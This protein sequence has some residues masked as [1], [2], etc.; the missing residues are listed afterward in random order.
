MRKIGSGIQQYSMD[1]N[2]EF[3]RS[4]HNAWSLGKIQWSA[5][6]LPY[7]DTEGGENPTELTF[8]QKFRCPVDKRKGDL[9]RSYALN[10]FFQLGP[11]DS[12]KGS[13]SRWWTFMSVPRPAATVLVAENLSGADHFM[14]HMWT[15]AKGAANAID[16][17][18][19]G[20]TSNYLF[21]DGHVESLPLEEVFDPKRNI[22][23]WNPSLAN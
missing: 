17:R 9:V 21:V 12:Y 6:I 13:P 2:N 22:N 10:V 3:P 18:R 20:K 15:T 14:S 16:S 1:N 7:I 23:K 11:G 8:T 19:H 4:L 5:A